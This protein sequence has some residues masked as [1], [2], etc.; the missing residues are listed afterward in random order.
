MKH[1]VKH[2]L[3]NNSEE[4]L[5]KSLLNCHCI[6]LHSIMLLDSPEKTIRLYVTDKSHEM[7][8]NLP[9]NF[10][11]EQM[12]I[13]FHTHHCN[14]TL[15]VIKGEIVHWQV[16]EKSSSNHQTITLLSWNY[17]SKISSGELKFDKQFTVH[18]QTD[19][20]LAISKDSSIFLEANKFHS[21][22]IKKGCVSAWLV[23]EGAED[24]NYKSIV[25]SQTYTDLNK[26]NDSNLY[27]KPTM[28]DIHMLLFLAGLI[29]EYIPQ[30]VDNIAQ[31]E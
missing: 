30:C 23:Y 10:N 9:E 24:E 25:Y 21:V 29:D 19:F 16:S 17:K 27:K 5:S 14:L 11:K 6:G 28:S 31:L 4:I 7:W 8:K 2:L 13:S 20:A 18:A 1:L 15:H 22:G 26:F 3:K 12:T